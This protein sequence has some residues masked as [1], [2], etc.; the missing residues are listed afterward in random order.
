[1]KTARNLAL[2]LLLLFITAFSPGCATSRHQSNATVYNGPIQES[3]PNTFW[4]DLLELLHDSAASLSSV[5][6]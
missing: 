1:M 2:L 3:K 5:Q 4:L 6:W